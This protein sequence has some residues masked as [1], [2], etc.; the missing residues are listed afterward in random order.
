MHPC[1]STYKGIKTW[2]DILH[3]QEQAVLTPLIWV[4]SAFACSAQECKAGAH[5]QSTEH[6]CAL[7]SASAAGEQLKQNVTVV[8][9]LRSF[10][11]A[12]GS[13]SMHVA[14]EQ[15]IGRTALGSKLR[16]VYVLSSWRD[17]RHA[18]CSKQAAQMYNVHA[19]CCWHAAACA[20]VTGC[21]AHSPSANLQ[22]QK[23]L[24]GKAIS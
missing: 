2:C 13:D 15:C 20:T 4:C 11:P 21:Q 16:T 23:V 3:P 10:W 12:T 1:T 9:V 7:A 17:Q 14:I 8:V 5:M 19:C 18:W 24:R 22:L 6:S